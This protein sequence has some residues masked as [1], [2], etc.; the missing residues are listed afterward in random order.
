MSDVLRR[1]DATSACRRLAFVQSLPQ[2]ER[3]E[4]V[5]GLLA[6]LKT[7]EET[8]LNTRAIHACANQ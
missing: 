6:R 4:L 1:Y 7:A 5:D 2:H 3:D 8:R